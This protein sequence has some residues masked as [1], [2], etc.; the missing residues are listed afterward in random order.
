MD[1]R[2]AA[3]EIETGK[4]TSSVSGEREAAVTFEEKGWRRGFAWVGSETDELEF[5]R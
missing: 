4:K 5:N 2:H 1:A 3:R